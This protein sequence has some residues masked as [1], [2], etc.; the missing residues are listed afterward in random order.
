MRCSN[1]Y[2]SEVYLE[3]EARSAMEGQQEEVLFKVDI[4]AKSNQITSL[5]GN[6]QR[7]KEV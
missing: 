1:C 3:E 6:R 2:Q 7:V 4:E 5:L